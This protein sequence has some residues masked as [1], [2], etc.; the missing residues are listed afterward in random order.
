MDP[1]ESRL[2]EYLTVLYDP[3]SVEKVWKE[4]QEKVEHFTQRHLELRAPGI[5]RPLTQA[6]NMLITYGDQV[7][8]TGRPRLHSLAE[9][10]EAQAGGWVTNLHI[11]PFY[12]YSSD[13]GF[14]VIDYMRVDE[15]LGTW[16][17]IRHLS[18][19][20]G[21]M[22]D[23]VINHISSQSAWFQK[24]LQ[25]VSLYTGYFIEV[26]PA[27]DLSQVFRP[28]ALPL[29]TAVKV[30]QEIRSVWT[31]FSPDQVDLNFANPDVL[32]EI[33]DVL[34]FYLAN[35]ARF[36]RLDAIA[37]LW[38]EIGSRC[39]HL[40]QTHAVVKLMHALCEVV[41][42]GTKLITETNVP[43]QENLSYFGNG[44]DEAHL[45]YNFALPP[46]V[47][48]SF[49]VG[50]AAKLS[51]WAGGLELPSKQVTFFNFLASHD[52][53]GVTPARGILA[54]AEIDGL[55]EQVRTHGGLVSSRNLP[56][57]SQI[58]YELNISYFDALSDPQSD[59][60]LEV[61]LTRF[62][63]AH[64]IMLSLVGMPGIYFH[65]L[66]GSRS[67]RSGVAV[68]GHN[69]TI[70]RQK[71]EREELENEL[72][73]PETLRA[74]V[75][76]RMKTLLQVRGAHQAFSPYAAQK[77]IDLSPAVFCILRGDPDGSQV[78]CLHNVSGAPLAT[79]LDLASL[80]ARKAQ[81]LLGGQ[82]LAG[83]K[84]ALELPPYGMIWLGL[85]KQV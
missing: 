20:F 13:D 2:L 53:I 37:F 64:A 41:A 14:S 44:E 29:L 24:Y 47:L 56:D 46:L 75:F 32:L 51:A 82:S 80:G 35:Q 54:E 70:N 74:R 83:E 34:L 58:P 66:F 45:V 84:L 73:S 43:H 22:F 26:D 16:D 11:L 8:E 50:D 10:L 77:I 4:L 60:A 5:N 38:K 59:E 3:I 48:H 76:H 21:L 18:Q 71:L 31:T 1:A 68:T 62:I 79:T 9:F 69:R 65:S 12:P 7:Y 36:I 55:V 15:Q 52:G 30:G 27:R 23:A 42:P 57:G 28:R 39:L 33:V 67:W 6:D 72:S 63:T 85:I 81:D 19:G 49:R 17:D 78:I 61:Q 25:G 40:P